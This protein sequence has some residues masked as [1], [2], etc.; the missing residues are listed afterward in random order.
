M[1]VLERGYWQQFKQTVQR[2]VIIHRPVDQKP[3]TLLHF[4]ACNFK[5]TN[6]F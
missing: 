2:D 3:V 1:H 6:I 4:L 5:E